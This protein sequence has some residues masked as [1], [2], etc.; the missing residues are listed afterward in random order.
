MPLL[1]QYKTKEAIP[2]DQVGLYRQDGSVWVL[3][4]EGMEPAEKV[5]QFRNANIDL[6]KI[7]AR[8][9]ANAD[10]P[11]TV[12]KVLEEFNDL[13]SREGEIRD[14]RL[15]KAGKVEEVV[16]ERIK[17]ARDDWQT[18]DRKKDDTIRTLNEQLSTVT[19]DRELIDEATK[20][21]VKA[22]AVQDIKLRGRATFKMK[23]GKIVAV[24]EKGEPAYGKDTKPLTIPEFIS[25]LATTDSGKH[26]FEPSTGT[27]SG[28]RRSQ[29]GGA[30]NGVNPW[31]QE[32]WSP[33]RQGDIWKEDKALARRL[34]AE[35][36]KPIPDSVQ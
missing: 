6:K 36:G 16:E 14:A 9:G 17:K 1:P 13:K 15:I 25:D 34:A 35:A 32:T 30:F 18:S 20:L 28:D 26:L 22:S 27:H 4:V 3:D 24:D 10:D 21:G 11:A 33:L 5:S 12:D 7:V 31:K 2:S 19:I 29:G 8:F 23:D